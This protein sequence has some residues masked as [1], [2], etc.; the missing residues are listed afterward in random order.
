M[1]GGTSSVTS[2]SKLVAY[3]G[4]FNNLSPIIARMNNPSPSLTNVN[5]DAPLMGPATGPLYYVPSPVRLTQSHGY[6]PT[7]TGGVPHIGTS[8]IPPSPPPPPYR[9]NPRMH[10][11]NGRAQHRRV[12]HLAQVENRGEYLDNFLPQGM[13]RPNPPH[14]RLN[15]QGGGTGKRLGSLQRKQLAKKMEICNIGENS[16]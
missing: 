2:F 10:P 9:T 12:K 15:V 7:R 13:E 14:A 16:W 1:I 8:K 4:R 6:P 5:L 3:A 11:P